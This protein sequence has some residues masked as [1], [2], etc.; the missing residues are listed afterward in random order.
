MFH[1]NPTHTGLSTETAIN[2]TSA[3]TLTAGWTASVG[4]KSYVSPAV[5]SNAKLGEA[6]VYAGGFTSKDA[7]SFYAYPA[8]GGAPIWSYTLPQGSDESSPAVFANVVY[9]A[10]TDG[11]LFAL[12]ATTGA[13]VCSFASA[14]FAQSSPVV[15]ND[16]DGSGPV[17][18]FGTSPNTGGSEFAIYGA[19]NTHGACTKDW[20]FTKF[21]FPPGG[22]WSSPAYGTDANGV[23]LVI[24]GSAD[25][26]NAVYALN[27]NTGKLVWYYRAVHSQND[28][29]VGAPP[30]ISPPGV[31][32]FA[33]GVV[34]VEGKGSHVYALNLTTGAAI[35]VHQLEAGTKGDVSGTALVGNRLYAGSDTGV[36]G[37]SALTGKR[38]WHVLP[39]YTFYCSAAISGPAGH[40]VLI[41]AGISGTMYA[42]NLQADGAILWQKKVNSGMWGSVAISQGTIYLT[43]MDGMLRSFAPSG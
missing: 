31:N 40:R 13:L 23:P 37:L 42:L 22:T 32:G 4:V 33:D 12:N 2:S 19:G 30:T 29:D 9:F 35:W 6:V 28:D 8:A 27:G 16:P 25:P 3:P 10:S 14:Q 1:A 11:A 18:Y 34:Y 38:I 26:D 39:Q 7:G 17:V 5:V 36:Y 21:H 20:Q 43:G 15:V 41:I 24:F